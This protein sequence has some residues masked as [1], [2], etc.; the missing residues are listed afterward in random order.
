MLLADVSG[1]RA[2]EKGEGVAEKRRAEE[3][4]DEEM[5]HAILSPILPTLT[6]EAPVA[7]EANNFSRNHIRPHRSQP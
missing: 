1:G 2:K 3:G 5:G 4:G 7:D 6:L